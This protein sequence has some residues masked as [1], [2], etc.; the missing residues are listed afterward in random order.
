M[1]SLEEWMSAARNGVEHPGDVPDRVDRLP[2]HVGLWLDR[3]LI[4]PRAEDQEHKSRRKLYD[5]AV[6][7][8]R[9]AT[10]TPAI[11]GYRPRFARWKADVLRTPPGILRWTCEFQA[12]SRILLHPATGSTVTEGSLLLHHTYGVPYL[13]GSALKGLCRARAEALHRSGFA[14]TK[15]LAGKEWWHLL[16]GHVDASASSETSSAGLFDFWDA[17]WV[18]EAPSRPVV[19]TDSAW[20]PLALDIV[21]PHHMGYYT[22]PEHPPPADTDEPKPT[23][24]L[25][26]SPG[27]RFHVVLEAP[28]LDGSMQK[29]LS[30]T[31]HALLIP[32]LGVHGIGARTASGYG[33]L[34]PTD[35][36]LRSK[37]EP[38]ATPPAQAAPNPRPNP[39]TVAIVS[40][41][42]N[43][44][45]LHARI[46]GGSSAEARP[47][48][49]DTLLRGL[50]ESVRERL[51][52][53][54]EVRLHV[55]WREDGRARRIVALREPQ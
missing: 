6:A 45:T 23:H 39:V 52:R 55:E 32:A 53:R 24:L 21:N 38:G 34:E 13:P 3:C 44:R 49:S 19:E 5:V 25:T 26:V 9:P 8:L 31:A 37:A 41:R 51:R 50:S 35:P 10:V 22:S 42:P 40:W 18:P 27:A 29:L 11:A 28:A 2:A 47:P 20:S 16:F 48:E 30:W 43:D 54:R 1:A 15:A 33:R 36:D 4:F 17:L 14:P 12:T 7:A 46:E